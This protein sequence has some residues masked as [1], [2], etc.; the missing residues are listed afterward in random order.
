MRLS[1]WVCLCGLFGL[2]PSACLYD[3][4]DRCGPHQVSIS[5]DRCA[6]EENFIPGANGCVPCGEN[7]VSLNGACS[8]ADGFARANIGDPCELPPAELGVECDTESNP[9]TEARYP[10]CHVTEGTSGYCTNECGSSDDC[11]GAYKCQGQEGGESFCR[12]PPVGLSDSCDSDADCEGKEATACE[13]IQS[14]QCLVPCA[15]G[16]TAGCFVGDACC[17]FPGPFVACVPAFACTAAN[18]GMVVE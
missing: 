3:G 1:G 15:A 17:S 7:E 11:D 2:V 13:A 16:D 10:L 5:N 18:F 8:C 14:H 6:C 9:C 12:R 4:D